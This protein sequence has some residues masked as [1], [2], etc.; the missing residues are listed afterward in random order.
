VAAHVPELAQVK[1]QVKAKVVE[2]KAKEVAQKTGEAA[3]AQLQVDNA[4]VGFTEMQH[5]NRIANRLPEQVL[6]TIMRAPVDKLPFYVGIG[7]DDCYIVA[8][9]E[10]VDKNN[11]ELRKLF[12]QYQIPALAQ[13][14]GAE[15]G[16]GFAMNLRQKNKI[17]IFPAAQQAIAGEQKQ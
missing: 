15:V 14:V 8:R 5:V 1:E 2:E 11:A 3:L 6:N 7:F 16:K 17:E 4:T 13:I 10:A 9:I 12:E